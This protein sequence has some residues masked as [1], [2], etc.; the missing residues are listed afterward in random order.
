MGPMIT[1]P[2]AKQQVS[3]A[4]SRAV[5]LVSVVMSVHNGARYLRGA[6]ESILSQTLPDLELIVVDD[7]SSDG[8]GEICREYAQRDARVVFLANTDRLGLTPS[9]N[10]AL[11]KAHG[12]YMARMD[13]DDVSLP[14]RF[15]TQVSYLET[16]VDVGLV[17][18]FYTEI[19]EDGSVLIPEY[20]F[21]TE[22]IIICWRMAFENPLPHPPI[23][24]RRALIEEVGRYDE[25]WRTSQDFDLFT[26]LCVL[27]KLA[28]CPEVL[29]EWRRHAESISTSFKKEQRDSAISISRAYISRLLGR[30]V[31]QADVE[32]LWQREPHG[33]KEAERFASTLI[34]ICRQIAAD[35]RWSSQER[36][37]LRNYVSQKLLYDL[38]PYARRPRSWR[39]LGSLACLSPSLVAKVA[40]RRGKGARPRWSP[41]PWR[42]R[43]TT[44]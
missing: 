40:T 7:A 15:K 32:L 2:Q 43:I 25:R 36:C 29:F 5:P 22:P 12:T 23:M 3:I 11:S 1:Y 35:S 27:T 38:T 4:E 31:P 17:G 37:A 39:L 19:D 9:L 24:A 33:I 34:A 20:R 14:H 28:N 44:D 16:H 18:S 10:R 41:L 21:P 26:R 6:I 42:R 30:D 8:S 13:A